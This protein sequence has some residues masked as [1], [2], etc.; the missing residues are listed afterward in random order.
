[1]QGHTYGV[2]AWSNTQLASWWRLSLGVATIWKKFEVDDG[3]VD[4]SGR[5]ALGD[6]P[7]YQLLARTQ[8]DIAP[9]LQATIGA[10]LID[11]IETAPSIR[12]YVEADA[13]LAYRVSDTVELYVAGRN[14]IH[15]SHDESN[16]LNQAQ[17]AQ[18][19]VF[20]GTRLRF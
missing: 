12:R 17:L 18:R 14:L 1:L 2:E 16:D 3:A 9:K 7:T 6:D 19:S 11:E 13:R 10:R 20:A 8:I 4:I 15:R 5:A